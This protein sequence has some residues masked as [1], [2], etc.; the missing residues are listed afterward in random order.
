MDFCRQP[1][2]LGDSCNA[3]WEW[4]SDAGA[5]SHG[6]VF[7]NKDMCLILTDGVAR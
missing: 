2:Q 7:V 6:P 4:M 5:G 1:S 3:L